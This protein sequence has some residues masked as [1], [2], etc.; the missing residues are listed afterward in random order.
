MN[1]ADSLHPQAVEVVKA[2]ATRHVDII[3]PAEVFA[4]TINAMG[5]R[6]GNPAAITAGNALLEQRWYIPQADEA[7][8]ESTLSRLARHKNSVSYIDCLVMAWA[9][10]YHTQTIFG[11]DGAFAA[12]GYALPASAAM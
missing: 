10:H 5:K 2:L 12:A 3:L 4:E 8:L 9:D 1:E 11:F 7:M 6:F